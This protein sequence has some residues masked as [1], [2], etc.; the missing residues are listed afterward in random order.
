MVTL[1]YLTR[2]YGATIEYMVCRDRAPHKV[3]TSLVA[4]DMRAA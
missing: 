2:E 1:H 3:D 4:V